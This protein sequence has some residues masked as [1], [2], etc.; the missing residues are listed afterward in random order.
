MSKGYPI[1]CYYG[2]L[3]YESRENKRVFS[4]NFVYRLWKLTGNLDPRTGEEVG[5][6]VVRVCM[7]SETRY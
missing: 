4:G 2:M 1:F 6:R 3:Y 7:A 5:L